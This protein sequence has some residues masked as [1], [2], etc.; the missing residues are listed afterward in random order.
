MSAFSSLDTF[1]DDCMKLVMTIVAL[2]F[3]FLRNGFMHTLWA[4]H[5]SS[6]ARW[7]KKEKYDQSYSVPFLL[8]EI[9]GIEF[10]VP[11]IV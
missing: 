9:L 3:V 11:S 4:I 7:H 10:R 8:L 6:E 1:R 2:T 5:T